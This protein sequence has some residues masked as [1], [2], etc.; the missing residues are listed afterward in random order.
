MRRDTMKPF[1]YDEH[2]G[3]WPEGGYDHEAGLPN[4]EQRREWWRTVS[5]RKSRMTL[6]AIRRRTVYRRLA[7]K[8]QAKKVR[9]ASGQ[10][11]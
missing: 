3:Q 1:R 5:S 11:G 7:E 8:A 6:R 2:D 10:F 9:R 4:R